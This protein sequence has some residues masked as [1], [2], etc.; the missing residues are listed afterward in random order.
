MSRYL[1][2]HFLINKDKIKKI[3][4]ALDLKEG[5][6]V[7]EIGPGHGELTL[8]LARNFQF[9][10][11]NFRII[12][13]EKDKKLVQILQKKFAS[14]KNI[15]IIEGDALKILPKL[16]K[17]YK[18]KAKSYKIVGNIPY[19]ITGYLLRVLAELERKPSLIVL[20]IQKE[21]AQRIIA[22]RQAQGKPRM[23]LLA[24]SV[25]FWAEPEIIDYVSRKDFQPAPEV[26]SAVI[27]MM[28]RP[29]LPYREV[30]VLKT[31]KN[32]S[33]N[34]YRLIKIL[35]K[36]PRK[37][38]LNNILEADKRGS[39]RIIEADKRGFLSKKLHKI[40]VSPSDRPE[41]LSIKQIREL[42]TLF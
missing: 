13:I 7:I 2:Q 30:P 35:F 37:T 29:A 32:Y 18:L 15:R 9:P 4:E 3:V 11:S 10:I 20:T 38:I 34:Y 16:T 5:D 28:V 23:N 25:Q 41:N 1:G 22:L 40:G 42:S 26:D 14:D 6:T 31:S 36:Q 24:A 27:K 8:L 19:Y 17:S 39:M 33:K 12:T 21:V